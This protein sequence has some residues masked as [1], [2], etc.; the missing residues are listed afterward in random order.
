MALL[1]L[2][3]K[4]LLQQEF[5]CRLSRHS[6]GGQRRRYQRLL[7]SFSWIFLW[8]QPQSEQPSVERLLQRL[9]SAPVWNRRDRQAQLGVMC[10][11]PLFVKNSKALLMWCISVC[12]VQNLGSLIS[13]HVVLC[14]CLWRGQRFCLS[15][16]HLPPQKSP[17][18]KYM[19]SLQI[20]YSI[21]TTK[22]SMCGGVS[23]LKGCCVQSSPF[24]GK[25]VTSDSLTKG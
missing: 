6:Q 1:A 11:L 8:V 20:L 25:L 23:G 7:F 18:P 2:R 14:I 17:N 22:K 12:F 16:Q 15:L 3:S 24:R 13:L 5:A 21:H 4:D 19:N 9:S 10:Q